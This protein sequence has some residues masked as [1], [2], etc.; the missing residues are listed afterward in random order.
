[1]PLRAI[2]RRSIEAGISLLNRFFRVVHL[3][4]KDLFASS[5][6]TA[7]SSVTLANLKIVIRTTVPNHSERDG[8]GDF[9]FAMALRD[10][11]FELGVYAQVDTNEDVLAGDS[12]P[13]DA[14]IDLRG[15]YGYPVDRKRIH[16]CWI[17]SHPESLN[18]DALNAYDHVFIASRMMA[19]AWDKQSTVTVESMSQATDIRRF[20]PAP[21]QAKRTYARNPILY[22][23][24]SRKVFRTMPR[25]C[26]EQ[27]LPVSLYGANWDGM[28]PSS[29]IAGE[30]IPNESLNVAYSECSILLNDHWDSMRDYGFLSNRFYDAGACGTFVIS[31]R[32]VGLDEEFPE[33]IVQ[34]TSAE[35][36]SDKVSYFLA[37]EDE[38][39]RLAAS[40]QSTIL[41]RDTFIH[42]ATTFLK[43]IERLM[44]ER[45]SR[46]HFS[47]TNTL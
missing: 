23:G 15:R 26:V 43:T 5:A 24:N 21:P 9:H 40:I 4:L 1:M 6:K 42:R 28:I 44:A 18:V 13:W 19:E 34:V 30:Y 39:V 45:S 35:E 33:S 46:F 25:W 17:I 3:G 31:D 37:H 22:V 14:V 32:V 36:L 7:A 38:R 2:K 8:W 12:L 11:F 41:N 29:M 47:N 16:L 20:K 27:G 10:A